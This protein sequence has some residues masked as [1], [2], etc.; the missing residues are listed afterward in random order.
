MTAEKQWFVRRNETV[1]GPFASAQ[2]TRNI[3]L[4]KIR[5]NDELSSNKK[6]W[7]AVAKHRELYPD[8]AQIE[9][10]GLETT[11]DKP[12]DT[13]K[14]KG[15]EKQKR[16]EERRYLQERRKTAA[17]AELIKQQASASG[18]NNKSMRMPVVSLILILMFIA[19]FA[20]QLRSNQITNKADCLSPAGSGVNWHSCTLP[21]LQVENKNLDASVLRDAIL[22]EAKLMGTSF[23]NADMAYVELI[24][25][26]LSY[27][28][29]ESAYLIGANLR[30]ADLRYSNLKGADLSYADLS[31]ALLAGANMEN[32]RLDNTIWFD[33]KVCA[34]GSLGLC[35]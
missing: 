11:P 25:S 1:Q 3:L 24:K 14:E 31:G 5:A 18:R 33:G 19:F 35:R 32:T 2:I 27:T 8:V 4:G 16:A 12:A 22:N 26:D 29:L 28:N 34:K 6:N 9:T 15:I 17:D 30:Q 23:I 20:Y 13:L 7:Q 21:Y 10:S